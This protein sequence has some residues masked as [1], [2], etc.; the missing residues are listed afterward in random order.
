MAMAGLTASQSNRLL[1]ALD[2]PFMTDDDRV[3]SLF[4]ATLSRQPDTS[5]RD[6]A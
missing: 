3:E 1:A 5:E 6:E 2:A 4:L